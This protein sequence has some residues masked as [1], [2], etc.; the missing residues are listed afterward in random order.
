[1][2]RPKGYPKTGG[3]QKGYKAPQTIEREEARKYLRD[4]VISELDPMLTAQ[5]ASAKGI[6]HFFLRDPKTKQFSRIED[7][8]TIQAAL[9]MGQEGSYYWIFTKDPSAQAFKDLMDRT[10]D[11]PKEHVELTGSDGGPVLYRWAE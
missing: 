2:G 9:N 11:R 6:N 4:R 5:I 8:D 3:K 7:P 10:L 1:M